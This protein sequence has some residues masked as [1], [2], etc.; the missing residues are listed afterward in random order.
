MVSNPD[1]A[2]KTINFNNY[3]VS[4]FDASELETLQDIWASDAGIVD[5]NDNPIDPVVNGFPFGDSHRS[6]GR[7][8]ILESA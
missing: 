4:S 7:A 8:W 2:R 6:L 5:E 3:T 1:P